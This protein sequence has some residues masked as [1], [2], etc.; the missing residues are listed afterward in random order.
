[1]SPLDETRI[2]PEHYL[3]SDRVVVNALDLENSEANPDAPRFSLITQLRTPAKRYKLDELD[4]QAYAESMEKEGEGRY[5]QT[6]LMIKT[7]LKSAFA[8]QLRHPFEPESLESLFRLLSGEQPDVTLYRGQII[9]V[10]VT[11]VTRAGMIARLDS[12]LQAWIPSSAYPEG[13]ADRQ[14]D[15]DIEKTLSDAFKHVRVI[16]TRIDFV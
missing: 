10:V 11:S 7:E 9:D 14:G 15:E 5:L 6:L 12:G 3:L 1:I 4:L 2:H 16:I 13:F 8:D